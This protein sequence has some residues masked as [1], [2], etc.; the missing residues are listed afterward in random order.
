LRPNDPEAAGGDR[1]VG[2]DRC[3]F[4]ATT[5]RLALLRL[6]IEQGKTDEAAPSSTGC[7]PRPAAGRRRHLLRYQRSSSPATSASS[8]SGGAAR[9]FIMYL[10]DPAPSSNATPLPLRRPSGTATS[11]PSS[12]GGPQLFQ[13]DPPL[14]DAGRRDGMS[15]FMPLPD[16]GPGVLAPGLPANIKRYIGL[17][18]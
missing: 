17:A 6:R 12:A 9:R 5:L 14:F 7:S 10:Y 18:V 2:G 15:S 16:D 4:S 11:R 8:P 3:Q 1:G 13:K